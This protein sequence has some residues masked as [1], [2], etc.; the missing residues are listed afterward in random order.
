VV[1][2]EGGKI[3]AIGTFEQERDAI[4]NFERQATAIGL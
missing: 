1:Y 4:P 3:L 2:L